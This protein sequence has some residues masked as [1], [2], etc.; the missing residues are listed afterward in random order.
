LRFLA[1]V[2]P[3]DFDRAVQ[4]LNVEETLVLVNS[5]TFTTAETILNAK[6]VRKWLLDGYKNIENISNEDIVKKH[7]C[8]C[9]TNLQKTG[10]FGIASENVF[11]FWDFVGGRFSVWSAIGVLP[12]AI[13]FGYDVAQ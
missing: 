9:S 1:N 4:G 12:L 8:A 2:D 7:I 10:E 11:G 6:S 5:K 13:Q 3:I